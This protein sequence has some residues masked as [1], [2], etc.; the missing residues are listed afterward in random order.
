MIEI[1][2]GITETINYG[3]LLGLKVFHNVDYEDYPDHWHVG[4]EMIMPV[5]SIYTVIVGKDR[6]QLEV[7]DIIIVNSG[8]L[9]A[10]E[11]PPSGERIIMQFNPSLLYTLKEMETLLAL[12][13]SA[14]CIRKEDSLHPIV[15]KHMDRI[16]KEYDEENTFCE[17]V[18]YATL[19]EMFVEIGRVVMTQKMSGS[20]EVKKGKTDKQMEY[21]EVIMKACTYINQHYQEKLK[22]EDTAATVG[23]SKFHFTRIFKQY[24]N[25][26]FYEYLN[27][28]R[29]ECA[30]GLLCSTE[31]SITD[32][33]MNSGF[34]SM[35]AF[36]RT[37]KSATGLSPSEFRSVILKQKTGIA[38]NESENEATYGMDIPPLERSI[39]EEEDMML[40]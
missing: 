29:V 32:V 19:I 15:K 18:V 5:E 9:H 20:R 22:L 34:S 40:Q 23:F 2:N 21:L 33:A 16:V 24:M 37:F 11:A 14:F 3:N 25:M 36:D 4:I 31:M 6:Y 28:K 10:L 26:T 12:L 17:A 1:L 30:E 35:S 7:G 39:M 38:L 13:P 27:K 8:I